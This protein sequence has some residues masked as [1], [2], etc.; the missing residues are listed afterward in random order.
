MILYLDTSAWVKLYAAEPG[1]DRVRNA[2]ERARLVATHLIAYVELRAALGRK[3]RLREAADSEIDAALLQAT[4]DWDRLH[5]L[6]LDEPLVMRAGE[7][8]DRHALRAYDA[9]HLAAAE[10]LQLALGAPVHF[11]CFDAALLSAVRAL[12]IQVMEAS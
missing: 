3:R 11:A 10:S 1:A 2:V 5:R 4:A 9:V 6:P 8:A 7:L 12:G